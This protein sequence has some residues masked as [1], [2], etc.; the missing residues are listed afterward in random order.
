LSEKKKFDVFNHVLVPKHILLNQEEAKKVL[1]QYRIEPYQLPH[2]KLS[3]PAVRQ[4]KAGVGD[5]IK[6]V[7]EST[8]YGQA[9]FYRYVIEG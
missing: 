2:I 3:D 8:T 9:F 4:I 6:I 7:R 5:V 1:S